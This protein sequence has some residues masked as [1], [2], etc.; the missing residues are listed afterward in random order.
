MGGGIVID[1]DARVL[2]SDDIRL[3]GC[4]QLVRRQAASRA[5]RLRDDT[6]VACL[7]PPKPA[8]LR[9]SM[10]PNGLHPVKSDNGA[11]MVKGKPVNIIE[12]RYPMMVT[13]ADRSTE[14]VYQVAE[15]MHEAFDQYKDVNA[16]TKNW[17]ISTAGHLPADVAWHPGAIKFLKEKGV[18]NAA[19]EAWN[20]KRLARHAKVI[21]EW[22]NATD[23]FNKWRVAEKKKKNKIKV[24]EAWPKYWADH[25]KKVGLD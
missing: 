3:K 18:W 20:T 6:W 17:I 9:Q 15:A 13:Y 11:G 7:N 25:R 23:A 1:G 12:F 4:M 21:E 14:E 10:R 19:D 22:D 24:S 8:C 2:R 16:T 5:V